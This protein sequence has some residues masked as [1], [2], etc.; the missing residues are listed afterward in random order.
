MK[1]TEI[2]CYASYNVGDT[3]ILYSCTRLP[4]STKEPHAYLIDDDMKVHK[5]LF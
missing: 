3:Y 4:N 2:H 5:I 1:L